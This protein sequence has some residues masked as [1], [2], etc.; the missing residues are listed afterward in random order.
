MSIEIRDGAGYLVA[1]VTFR[2]SSSDL[3][4]ENTA[5]MAESLG[6]GFYLRVKEQNGPSNPTDDRG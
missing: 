2:E 6:Q 4:M 1:T 5:K 3:A